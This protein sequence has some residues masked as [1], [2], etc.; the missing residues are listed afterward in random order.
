MNQGRKKQFA[1]GKGQT[2]RTPCQW[3][4]IGVN[5]NGGDIN[6]CQPK[7]KSQYKIETIIETRL[8]I[9]VIS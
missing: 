1:L 9:Q 2:G 7:N 5:W 3:C 4:W 8:K 6:E